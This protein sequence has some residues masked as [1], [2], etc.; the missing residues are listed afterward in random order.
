M[1]VVRL[2]GNL[3]AHVNIKTHISLWVQVCLI[4][5]LH[6]LKLFWIIF[7]YVLWQ[8]DTLSLRRSIGTTSS[9]KAKL[10]ADYITVH[11]ATQTSMPSKMGH[12]QYGV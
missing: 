6:K 7:H 4:P 8:H 5:A 9:S 3:I 12:Y 11:Y 2:R 10:L 1:W